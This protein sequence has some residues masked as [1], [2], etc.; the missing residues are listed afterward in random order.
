MKNPYLRLVLGLALAVLCFGELQA[1]SVVLNIDWSNR[2]AV[3]ITATTANSSYTY[4]DGSPSSFQGEDGVTLLGFLTSNYSG[5]NVDVGPVATSATLTDTYTGN[6]IFDQLYVMNVT[7]NPV[8]L[9]VYSVN[10]SGYLG[11]QSGSQAFSGESVWDLSASQYDSFVNSFPDVGA[12]GSI[13]LYNETG[14]VVGNWEVVGASAVPEPATY[15]VLA[16]FAALLGTMVFRR[17]RRVQ[18]EC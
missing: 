9:N 15:A 12:T 7:G 13:I 11:F 17:S 3:K 10:T 5:T 16:G 1:Q 2:S 6:S 18:I 8:D 14:M 4:P